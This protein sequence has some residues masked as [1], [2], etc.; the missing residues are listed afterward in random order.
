MIFQSAM[1]DLP[2]SNLPAEVSI[3]LQDN[4]ALCEQVARAHAMLPTQP[5]EA[6]TCLEQALSEPL[7]DKVKAYCQI[8]L[9]D[10]YF[11]LNDI[12]CLRIYEHSLELAEQGNMVGLKAASLHGLARVFNR[13]GDRNSSLEYAQQALM[14][15]QQHQLNEYLPDILLTIS[16]V[17]SHNGEHVRCL[18][19]AREALEMATRS[20]SLQQQFRANNNTADHMLSW[21]MA[22]RHCNEPADHGLVHKARTHAHAAW[23]IAQQQKSV[24]NQ[25]A[26][27]ETLAHA[28]E[29]SGESEAALSLLQKELPALTGHGFAPNELD[30][31]V[32]IGVLL[33]KLGRH[34]EAIKQLLDA[35]SAAAT[36]AFYPYL[37]EILQALSTA[38]EELGDHLQALATYKEFHST[39]LSDR[40]HRAE[41]STRLFAA[42]RDIAR[43]Q[44]EIEAQ[45]S[46]V[47]QLE[48]SNRDLMQLAQQDPL[49]SLPNRR[50]L[51][52]VM[53][54]ELSHS[55][56]ALHFVMCDIDRFKQ[57]N[58]RFSHLTGDAVLRHV[59]LLLRANLRAHDTAA[60]IGGEEFAL[61]LSQAKDCAD[62]CERIRKSIASFQWND[63]A[64]GL[65]VT[66]SFGYT[67]IRSGDNLTSLMQRADHALYQA[68]HLGRNCVCKG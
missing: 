20:G 12:R 7:R 6:S 15:A 13:F 51:E 42:K 45:R 8:W 5:R 49:T 43:V 59:A 62:V 26:V 29:L 58:D 3:E 18:D 39:V 36:L 47:D 57:I 68:K 14:H 31:Q 28:L 66:M 61:V 50:H 63:V 1:S 52:Q 4:P 25:L 33:L 65:L 67:E 53:T 44:C 40:D 64:D 9:A 54:D 16:M 60:R 30:L 27:L 46:R 24:R 34:P 38:Y 48:S 32:R 19:L 11:F 37:D 23:G 56:N 2:D 17:L 21:F 10:C 41:I 22:Q 55:D 35:K